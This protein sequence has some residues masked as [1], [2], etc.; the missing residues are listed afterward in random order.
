MPNVAF[1]LNRITAIIKPQISFS[2]YQVIKTV[3]FLDKHPMITFL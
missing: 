3:L 2:M 1:L